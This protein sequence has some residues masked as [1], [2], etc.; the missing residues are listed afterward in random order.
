VNG[1][2][3]TYFKQLLDEKFG[4]IKSDIEDIKENVKTIKSEE[5]IIEDFKDNHTYEV[6]NSTQ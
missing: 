2:E 4:N 5:N 3:K 6:K 1:D